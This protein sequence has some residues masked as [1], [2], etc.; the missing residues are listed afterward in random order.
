M[1]LI[2]SN[3]NALPME[4]RVIYFCHFSSK[5]TE[6]SESS[7][8]WTWIKRLHFIGFQNCY[9]FKVTV[10]VKLN[11]TSKLQVLLFPLQILTF[12]FAF[13]S[14]HGHNRRRSRHSR[15]G[16]Q[17]SCP[18]MLNKWGFTKAQ[19][20]EMVSFSIPKTFQCDNVLGCHTGY[21]V[22]MILGIKE[23]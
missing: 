18:Q 9:F 14:T 3:I 5:T 21:P 16:W 1:Y 13:S 20:C 15:S 2:D 12:F 6:N 23:I 10:E 8:H 22:S 7:Q 17:F 19:V 11:F 4:I